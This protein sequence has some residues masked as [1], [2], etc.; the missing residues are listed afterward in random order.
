MITSIFRLCA[1]VRRPSSSVRPFLENRQADSHQILLFAIIMGLYGRKK[2]RTSPLQV[3]I[4][5]SPP[6]PFVHVLL[7]RVSTKVQNSNNC[8]IVDLCHFFPFRLTGDHMGTKSFNRYL[9]WKNTPDVLP[10]NSCILLWRVSTNVV[11]RIVTFEVLIFWHFFRFFLGPFNMV[12][13]SQWDLYSDILK[14]A[15]RRAKRT[16]IWAS[17]VHVSS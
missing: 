5:F 14:I 3:N 16:K 7:G 2:I 12:A 9:L 6:K 8:E 15:S 1:G 10:P 4:N 17:G 13:T 11:K